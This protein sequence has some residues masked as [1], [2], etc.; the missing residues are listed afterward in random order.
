MLNLEAIL[1]FS[2][3]Q[4]FLKF[5]SNLTLQEYAKIYEFHCFDCDNSWK[6]VPKKTTILNLGAIL[7]FWEQNSSI[8]VRYLVNVKIPEKI[9]YSNIKM[10]L[11][12]ETL[13]LAAILDWAAILSL[14]SSKHFFLFYF[15]QLKVYKNAYWNCI[16]VKRRTGAFF[17]A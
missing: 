11:S 14:R 13:V 6:T 2:P 7:N 5:F 17:A 10:R 15:F 9:F 16:I 8:K 12:D 3:W 4:D 1:N